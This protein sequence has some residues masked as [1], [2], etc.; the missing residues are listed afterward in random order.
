MQVKL[1]FTRLHHRPEGP[2]FTRRFDKGKLSGNP[3]GAFPS[4]VWSDI[5]TVRHGHPERKNS[6]H[7]AQFPVLLAKRLILLYT[8]PGDLI[9]DPFCGS[10][11]SA[12]AAVESGR[13]FVGADLFYEGLRAQRIG[14]AKP[15]TFSKLPGVTDESVAVWQAEARREDLDASKQKE[16]DVQQFRQLNIF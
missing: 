16:S 4:D 12:V 8:M 6:V 9:C 15:D 11:T 14:M 5:P 7:P 2:C 3:F 1:R 10:G 13:N